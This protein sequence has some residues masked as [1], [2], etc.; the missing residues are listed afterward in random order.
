M[1]A[2]RFLYHELYRASLDLSAFLEP[3]PGVPGMVTFSEFD[4]QALAQ[5][6]ELGT[7]Q[8][9]ILRGRTFALP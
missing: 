6:R 5:S 7:I 1:N 3:Y 8:D 9:G 4:P 2:R